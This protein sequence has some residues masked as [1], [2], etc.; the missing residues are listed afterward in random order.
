MKL[1]SPLLLALSLV[2]SLTACSNQPAETMV[3]I[4]IGQDTS[5]AL[6]GMLLADYPGPK[7]QMHFEGGQTEFFCD[8]VEMFSIYLKPEQARRVK[9][10][11]VQDMGKADWAAPKGHW[12]DA[13]KAFYVQGSSVHGSMGP[14]IASFAS[15]ADARAFSEKNGGKVM[16]FKDFN[17]DMVV[18]DGGVLHDQQM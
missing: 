17:A 13:F 12:I 15:E 8:T 9:A 18:L 10:L 3:P 1:F 4:E 16:G 7:A 5:C 11:Y 14:T 6:D 2:A